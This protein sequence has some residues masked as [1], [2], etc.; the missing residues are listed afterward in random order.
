MDEKSSREMDLISR[1][2]FSV[3]RVFSSIFQQYVCHFHFPCYFLSA[4]KTAALRLQEII[5]IEALPG[6]HIPQLVV[7]NQII[8]LCG[9][10]GRVFCSYKLL[11]SLSQVTA[12][13]K[14]CNN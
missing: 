14:T 4:L 2:I 7:C 5:H 6:F 3:T 10:A 9:C 12:V 13:L 8:G 1:V 11:L